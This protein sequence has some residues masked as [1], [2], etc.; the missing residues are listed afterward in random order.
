MIV[1]HFVS[2]L[3]VVCPEKT[4]TV[5]GSGRGRGGRPRGKRGRGGGNAGRGRG[6][7]RG[8][9]SASHPSTV[10]SRQPSAPPAD[11][12]EFRDDSEEERPRLILTIKP[13]QPSVQPASSHQS[14]SDNAP[15]TRK[16]RRLQVRVFCFSFVEI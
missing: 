15:S 7:G 3:C 1:N 13:E 4:P 8:A 10:S 2:S 5:S 16:S 12:Y 6:G 9:S 14:S 11:V